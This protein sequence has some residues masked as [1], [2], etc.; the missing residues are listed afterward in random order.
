MKSKDVQKI[1]FRK[2]QDGDTPS[3]IVRHLNGCLGLTTIKRWCQMFRVNGAIELS[4]LTGRPC[5]ARTGKAIQKVKYKLTQNKVSVRGLTK[6][7]G[8]SKIKRA[9]NVEGR[10]EASRIQDRSRTKTH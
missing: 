4:T 1:V 7:V 10:S 5:L 8:I 2:Y 9:S 6:E 3:E